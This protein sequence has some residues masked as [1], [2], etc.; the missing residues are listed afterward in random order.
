MA[1]GQRETV[2]STL[3]IDGTS[4]INNSYYGAH[5]TG[6]NTTYTYKSGTISGNSPGNVN[7]ER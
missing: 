3:V 1:F 6:S 4:I 5:I 2:Y 7:D